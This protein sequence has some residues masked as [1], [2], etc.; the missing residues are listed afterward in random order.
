MIAETAQGARFGT[1]ESDGDQALGAR[2]PHPLKHVRRA[3]RGA[4]PDGHVSRPPDRLD[5]PREHTLEFGVV[6]DAGEHGRVRGQR[7]RGESR[8]VADVPVD[9]LGGEVL[10][11]RGAAA[12]AEEQ[13][14]AAAP[15]RRDEGSGRGLD[16]VRPLGEEALG[17]FGM[18]A[19][20]S[21]DPIRTA[22]SSRRGAA[23]HLS[24]STR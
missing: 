7:D 21:A 20:E 10:G 11:V 5:L 1:A 18:V 19:V 24:S 6:G 4:D 2:R 3:P 22:E 13:Q 14:G 12:V 23:L 15:E 16:R 9:E 17:R 8:A